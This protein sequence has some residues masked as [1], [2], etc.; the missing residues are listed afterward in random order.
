M[1]RL[2]RGRSVDIEPVVSGMA[3][4]WSRAQALTGQVAAW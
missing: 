2:A 1:A 4:D 3:S